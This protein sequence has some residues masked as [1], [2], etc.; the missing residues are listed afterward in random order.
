[1]TGVQTCALPIFLGISGSN[2]DEAEELA[3]FGEENDEK[4]ERLYTTVD[5]LKKRF[6]KDIIK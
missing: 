3:L 5:A 2:F 1:M 6:G 4:K